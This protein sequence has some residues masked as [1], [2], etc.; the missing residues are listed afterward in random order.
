MKQLYSI[1][2]KKKNIYLDKNLYYINQYGIIYKISQPLP[3]KLQEQERYEVRFITNG[4][5]NGN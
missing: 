2:D 4:A 3:V 5:K 1:Y